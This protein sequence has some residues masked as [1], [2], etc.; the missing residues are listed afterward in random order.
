MAVSAL[1]FLLSLRASIRSKQ[2]VKAVMDRTETRKVVRLC[3]H[4]TPDE[5]A[6]AWIGG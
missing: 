4:Q 2:I 1:C 6:D 3:G 5:C